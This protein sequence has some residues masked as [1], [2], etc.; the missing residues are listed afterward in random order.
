[1]SPDAP[2]VALCVRF[3][4]ILEPQGSLHLL[5][6]GQIGQQ[7]KLRQLSIQ[8]DPVEAAAVCQ[9]TDVPSDIDQIEPSKG[10]A[11]EGHLRH[12]KFRGF[13]STASRLSGPLPATRFRK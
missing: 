2:D 12:L 11:R 6:P 1:L 13:W 5:C 7:T 9:G 3:L 4:W 8:E 10:E